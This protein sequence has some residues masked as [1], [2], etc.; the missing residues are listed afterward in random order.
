MKNDHE[1]PEAYI[2]CTECGRK[3]HQ[4]CALHMESISAKFICETCTRERSLIS[5]LR[6]IETRFAAAKL[7]RTQLGDFLEQR[8]NSY[9]KSATDET[10]YLKSQTGRVTIRIL[11]SVDKICEIKP[12]IKQ[13][14]EGEINETFP[15]RTKAIFAFEEIDGTDVVFFGMHIQEYGSECSM[16]NTRRVYISYLDSV[17]F[18]RP[19]E[20]RT[21]VYH[22]ILIGYLDYAKRMGYQWAHIWACPPSEG[23]DYIFHCHPADQKV[24]KPKRLQDWYKKMLDKGIM[25]R[26]VIDYKDIHKDAIENGMKTPLDIPYF[27]GDFW[28]NV[29]EDCIKGS[30][31]MIF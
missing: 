11:S 28:P 31:K 12:A 7:T 9:L 17:F 13:R 19:K 20:L 21:S 5:N 16:P 14:F 1:E 23:D 6:R 27:E 3:W 26:V 4:I 2:D 25:E 22:E 8:V 15:F 18:F 30:I 10:P 29:L 24:P